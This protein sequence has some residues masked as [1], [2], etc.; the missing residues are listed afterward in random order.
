MS[1][2]ELIKVL[3]IAIESQDN[4]AVKV[5]LNMA[6]ERILE[7]SKIVGENNERKD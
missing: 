3:N 2:E 4:I 5:L 7:L 1:N 6:A